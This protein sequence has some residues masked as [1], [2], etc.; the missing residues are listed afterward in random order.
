MAIQNT[1]GFQD[2]I[3]NQEILERDRVK[4]SETHERIT[5]G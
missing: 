2:F 5:M 3:V 1:K 4:W